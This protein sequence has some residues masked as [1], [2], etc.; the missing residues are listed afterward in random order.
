VRP[1]TAPAAPAA[2][3]RAAIGR[4]P[5]IAAHRAARRP[6]GCLLVGSCI[7]PSFIV[8]LLRHAPERFA[9]AVLMQ[10]IG[11]QKHTTEPGAR[12]DGLNTFAAEHWFGSWAAERVRTGASTRAE[13]AA[14]YDAMFVQPGE[15]RFIFTASRD[16]IAAL[17][18]P[19]LVLA[20]K[21]RACACALRLRLVCGSVLSL[22]DWGPT[23]RPLQQR[24]DTSGVGHCPHAVP[25]GPCA[26]AAYLTSPCTCLSHC[27]R[28]PTTRHRSRETSRRARGRQS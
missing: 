27:T 13:L 15:E 18:H 26:S 22:T 24:T 5:P 28:T 4:A 25:G 9:A 19:L 12:W 2:A 20:G 7:G 8:N 11:L 1:T 10:P 23:L 14:L 3:T 6:A 16:D 17:R 21:V